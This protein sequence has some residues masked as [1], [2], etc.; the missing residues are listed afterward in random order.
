MAGVSL[1]RD[2]K[3]KG[4]AVGLFHPGRVATD[5]LGPDAKVRT[6]PLSC[7][8]LTHVSAV[9]TQV[10]VNE[11]VAADFAVKGLLGE[12]GH[13]AIRNHL[14][15]SPVFACCAARFAELNLQNTGSFWHAQGQILPW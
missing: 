9:S 4:I 7:D 5:M 3:P 2:L 13:S 14:V 8:L 10:G 6:T 12:S 11:T 1:A 15:L